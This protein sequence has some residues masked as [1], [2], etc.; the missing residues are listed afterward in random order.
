M[1]FSLNPNAEFSAGAEGQGPVDMP[2][3]LMAQYHVEAYAPWTI[4]E[5]LRGAERAGNPTTREELLDLAPMILPRERDGADVIPKS[6][7]EIWSLYWFGKSFDEMSEEFRFDEKLLWQDDFENLV[8]NAG[9]DD[10]L[11]KHFK[12]VSYSAAWYVGL[13]DGTPTVAAGDT[14]SSHAGWADLT[15]YTQSTRPA[16]TLGAV[17]GQSV[18]NSASKATFTIAGNSVTIGGAYVVTSS[19]K[20][21]TGGTLYG[22]GAFS[23]GDKSLDDGDT[24]NVQISLTAAAS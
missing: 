2:K 4:D 15:S 17:S 18:D 22:A 5:V 20:G 3:H 6:Q 19:T 9:L 11:D 1:D 10:S 23:A 7:L 8:V 13:T 24:L 12:A 21:G 14:M 16:L